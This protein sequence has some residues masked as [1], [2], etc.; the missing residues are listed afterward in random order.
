MSSACSR[1]SLYDLADSARLNWIGRWSKRLRGTS[2]QLPRQSH[3]TGST[4]AAN[5]ALSRLIVLEKADKEFAHGSG[6]LWG[7]LMGLQEG[8]EVGRPPAEARSSAMA[9]LM[10]PVS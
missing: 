7:Q 3:R 10:T 5:S 9:G 4:E 2:C 6:E 8:F 1:R